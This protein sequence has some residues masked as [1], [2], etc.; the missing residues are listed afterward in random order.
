MSLLYMV[1]L[2]SLH[3]MSLLYMVHLDSLHV[4]SLLYIIMNTLLD[5]E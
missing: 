4:M 2:D 5:R 1:H 3:F